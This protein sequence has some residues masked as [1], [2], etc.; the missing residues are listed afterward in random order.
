MSQTQTTPEPYTAIS[1]I[2]PHTFAE[3][4][5]EAR[6]FHGYPAPG[7][8][9]GGIMVQA[10][11]RRLPEGVLFDAI[12]EASSCLPDAVQI[13]TPCTAGN[14]WL[15]V[16][17]LGRYALTL[18]NKHTGEGVR[19]ALDPEKLQDWP[20][21]RD[22]FFK[23]KSKPEQDV[24]RLREE[25]RLAG[26]SVLRIEPAQVK[27]E[28]VGKTSKGPIRACPLC[29]EAYPE[30][31]G[32]I[33]LG[34]QG[35]A[36]V[37][38]ELHRAS[39]EGPNLRA[40]PVEEAVGRHV[41]HDMT[42]IEPGVS[43]GPAFTRGQAVMPGDVCR[44]QQMGRQRVY[45]LDEDENKDWV[46][47]DEAARL[48]AGALAPDGSVEPAGPPREGKVTLN[49]SHDGLL[50]VDEEALEAFNLAPRVMAATRP[51][52][53]LVEKGEAVAATRAIPLH[54]S[55]SETEAALATLAGAEPVR[56]LPLRKARA[57]LLITGTEVFQGLIED[58]FEPILTRK[59]EE[60]G[61]EVVKSLIRPDDREA[62]ASGLRELLD[63]GCDL[64]I[65]TAGLSV[66]PDDVTRQALLDA[67]AEDLLH[68]MPVLPGAMTLTG[69]IGQ[70]DL[71]G[72]PACALYFAV[73]SL[74]LLLPRILAGLRLSRRDLARLGAGG[75]CA[76]CEVCR[77]PHCPF[78]K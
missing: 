48:F 31:T 51:H 7:L 4:I 56:V 66:D 46:H 58:R 75:M 68:G 57:G 33:C 5:E 27:P 37:E 13:L 29:G 71:I 49:A 10:A 69:R 8:I 52:A 73:T 53:A 76:E 11:R 54:L 22:W 20:E 65:T 64:V 47:E 28:H 9:I 15:R 19:V 6:R 38:S 25:M 17:D 21:F 24:D 36:P 43:K 32:R 61:G 2:G 34:C 16:I 40:V 30:R 39:R 74:D 59:L 14:G 44:L 12:S 3:F 35:R 18:F 45:L 63:A 26:E 70:T 42:Q 62:I 67:G 78:G 41:A 50:A 55:R 23:A 60:F 1:H 72:V 77:F